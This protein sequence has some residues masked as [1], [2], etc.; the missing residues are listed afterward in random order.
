MKID[1]GWLA[2]LLLATWRLSAA[3]YYE[4][5]PGHLW[6]RLRYRAGVYAD[7][8]PFWGKQL[9]CF[10]C[11]SLWSGLICAMVG[12]WWWPGLLPLALSGAAALLSGGG[13]IIWRAMTE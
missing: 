10:W 6:A 2:V 8:R 13:R 5:G 9:A 11:V 12:C 1:L 7:P 4:D 3:I